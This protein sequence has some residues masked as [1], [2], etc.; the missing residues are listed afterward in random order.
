MINNLFNPISH[1]HHTL[2]YM[3][4]GDSSG[5]P[6]VIHHPY[7]NTEAVDFVY[8]GKTI[9]FIIQLGMNCDTFTNPP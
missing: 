4:M 2:L 9:P 8:S 5:D 1:S 7:K 6:I 3:Y